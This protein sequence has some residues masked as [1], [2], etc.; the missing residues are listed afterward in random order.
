MLPDIDLAV[1]PN[2]WRAQKGSD[3]M[4]P[5]DPPIWY[6]DPQELFISE[7]NPYGKECGEAGH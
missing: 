6:M 3:I 1:Q 5:V 4:I 7:R 2:G